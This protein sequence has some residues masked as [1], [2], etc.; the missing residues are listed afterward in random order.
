M[1]HWHPRLP[2]K[3]RPKYEDSHM[4]ET[5]KQA[6]RG[7]EPLDRPRIAHDPQRRNPGWGSMT[8]G[9]RGFVFQGS[10]RQGS[11]PLRWDTEGPWPSGRKAFR[12]RERFQPWRRNFTTSEWGGVARW[13]G[14]RTPFQ[15]VSSR[16]HEAL[17]PGSRSDAEFGITPS[18]INPLGKLGGH[19]DSREPARVFQSP[20]WMQWTKRHHRIKVE[21]NGCILTF[22]LKITISAP[23]K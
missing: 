21:T 1:V 4:D 22:I 19:L 17:C 3:E 16:A 10:T 12:W 11:A 15:W 7:S 5:P 18:L 8:W 2:L 9:I 20:S 23:P 13:S 6:Q 14:L